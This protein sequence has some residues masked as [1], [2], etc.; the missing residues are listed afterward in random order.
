[1]RALVCEGLEM[2]NAVVFD[3]ATC[4]HDVTSVIDPN[5][6]LWIDQ[7]DRSLPHDMVKLTDFDSAQSLQEN[8]SH[9][10]LG[11]DRVVVIA[12]EIDDIL[13]NLVKHLRSKRFVVVASSQHFLKVASDKWQTFQA[14]GEHV[15]QPNTWLASN[16]DQIEDKNNPTD[17]GFVLKPRDGAGGGG[18]KRTETYEQLKKAVL[19]LANPVQWVVQEWRSGKHCSVAML[20]DETGTCQVL[21]ATEQL[22]RF[23]ETGFHYL[24]ARGPIAKH[25]THGIENWCQQVLALIPGAFGWIGIDYIAT[26]NHALESQEIDPVNMSRSELYCSKRALIEINPRLT[27]SYLLYRQVYGPKLSEGLI[28]LELDLEVLRQTEGDEAIEYLVN[29]DTH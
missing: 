16:V 2:W 10:S 21:G 6:R 3:L 14:L 20:V 12:P 13:A 1:M 5:V 23:D 18:C 19:S 24:G 29:A 22:L 27:T 25:E 17:M 11:A 26:E 7:E 8:W 15:Q 28:G 4:G 9:A